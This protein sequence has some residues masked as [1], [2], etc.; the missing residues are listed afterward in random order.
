MFNLLKDKLK[1]FVSSFSQKTEQVK[2]SGDGTEE[3]LGTT[4]ELREEK[5]KEGETG[6][7]EGKEKEGELETAPSPREEKPPEPKTP[8]EK[9]VFEERYKAGSKPEL[10]EELEQ[11]KQREPARE[12]PQVREGQ[13]K[14]PERKQERQAVMPERK[15]PWRKEPQRLPE[16]EGPEEPAAR[17]E[18]K[19]QESKKLEAKL[20]LET[21]VRGIISNEI[22]IKEKDVEELLDGLNLSLLEADV[23]YEVAEKITLDIRK[24]VVGMKV[25]RGRTNEA[26]REAVSAAL[27]EVMAISGPDIF[28][29]A[30]KSEKPFK[31]LVMGPNGAGKTTTMAKLAS[32]FID[33]GHTCVFSASDTFR[34]A[35]IEQTEHHADRLGIKAIKKGYGAD[36]AA[37]AFDAVNYARSNKIDIVLIDSSGRQETNVNLVNEMKKMNR[38]VKPDLKLFVGE[39]IAG[40]ALV[41]QVRSFNEAVGID[42]VILTKLDCDAKGGT[43]LSVSSAT[44]VPVL[45]LG[46]GQ[47]YGDLRKFD[48][49]FIVKQL[50]G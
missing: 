32:M 48:P 47:A 22:E 35:A 7:R 26:I 30:E 13:H 15:E 50:M 31:I 37:V 46:V 21:R 1:S 5:E 44:G 20:S 4:P 25:A 29:L 39:S 27:R 9:L 12:E 40:N 24:R 34:A 16:K 42:G 17:E 3:R 19:P 10:R 2:E 33:A 11:R 45:F 41:N 28:A 8:D 36:P 49:D 38:V 23:A 43:A 14:K 18:R 6:G